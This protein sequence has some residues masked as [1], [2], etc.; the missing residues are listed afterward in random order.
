MDSLLKEALTSVASAVGLSSDEAGTEVPLPEVSDSVHLPPPGVA[1]KK[2][3][4]RLA[5]IEREE[6]ASLREQIKKAQADAAAEQEVIDASIYDVEQELA[7]GE[8]RESLSARKIAAQVASEILAVK[9]R[10]ISNLKAQLETKRKEL[11]RRSYRLTSWVSQTEVACRAYQV[12]FVCGADRLHP[13]KFVRA[14]RLLENLEGYAA[15][16]L[17]SDLAK[18]VV[19]SITNNPVPPTLKEVLLA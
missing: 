3:R 6:T 4:S 18:A 10:D 2:M 9:E 8:T 14:Y 19:A 16:I 5:E 1:V 13:E 7:N 17:G 12:S 15:E 11:H